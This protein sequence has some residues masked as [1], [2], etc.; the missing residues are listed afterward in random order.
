MGLLSAESAM[1]P[2]PL[3]QSSGWP[4]FSPTPIQHKTVSL[5]HYPPHSHH[6]SPALPQQLCRSHYHHRIRS[7]LSTHWLSELAMV[8]LSVPI[9]HTEVAMAPHLSYSCGERDG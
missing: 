4:L 1:R 8:Q 9:I 2:L 6:T 5:A 3:H 7:C